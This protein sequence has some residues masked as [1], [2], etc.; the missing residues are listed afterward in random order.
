MS[1]ESTTDTDDIEVHWQEPR[2]KYE[3]PLLLVMGPRAEWYLKLTDSHRVVAACVYEFTDDDIKTESIHPDAPIP[4]A[5]ATAVRNYDGQYSEMT[6]NFLN[7][8]EDRPNGSL[9]EWVQ[10]NTPMERS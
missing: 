3:D 10:E 1:D 5:V 9:V 8:I 6:G 2:H 4:S 7:P